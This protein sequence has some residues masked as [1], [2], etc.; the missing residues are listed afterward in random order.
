MAS[1]AYYQAPFTDLYPFRKAIGG[2]GSPEELVPFA[3]FTRHLGA[4][5]YAEY[6][7]ISL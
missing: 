7:E 4:D 6:G 1:L 5:I 3:T 2:S